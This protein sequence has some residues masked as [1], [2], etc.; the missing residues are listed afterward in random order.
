MENIKA[1]VR[2]RQILC[3]ERKIGDASCVEVLDCDTKLEVKIHPTKTAIYR[4]SKFFPRLT[5]Q[6]I[7]YDQ[8]GVLNLFD[9]AMDGHAVNIFAYG[10]H[11]S[12][13]TYTLFGPP[14]GTCERNLGVVQR[15]LKSIY[16]K[17]DALRVKYNVSLTCVQICEEKFYD[18]FVTQKERNVLSLQRSPTGSISVRDYQRIKCCNYSSAIASLEQV[19][20]ERCSSASPQNSHCVVE[21][22]INLP[23]EDNKSSNLNEIDVNVRSIAL[24]KISFVDLAGSEFITAR[25]AEDGSLI[26]ADHS[27]AVLSKTIDGVEKINN[28]N[29]TVMD[30]A[31][32]ALLCD[33]VGVPGCS[34]LISCIREGF[35]NI[36]ETVKTLQFRYGTYFSPSKYCKIS[37]SIYKLLISYSCVHVPK[38]LKY[39]DAQAKIAYDL[40]AQLHYLNRQNHK[41]RQTI[42][43]APT[44]EL[45]TR[46]HNTPA[47][48]KQER[49]QEKALIAMHNEILKA[50]TTYQFKPRGG[51][52]MYFPSPV[53]GREL[54]L[55]PKKYASDL[56]T[57]R[58]SGLLEGVS[59]LSSVPSKS[60][61]ESW[62]W[63]SS[64]DSRH[65]LR[66]RSSNAP[67]SASRGSSR[68]EAR[69]E[70]SIELKNSNDGDEGVIGNSRNFSSRDDNTSGKVNKKVLALSATALDHI[71]VR[72]H[73]ATGPL[74]FRNKRAVRSPETAHDVPPIEPLKETTRLGFNK[75]GKDWPQEDW[76]KEIRERVASAV[77][78]NERA[79]H[80]VRD[81]KLDATGNFCHRFGRFYRYAR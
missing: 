58:S 18:M 44:W 80:L 67:R 81:P 42:I 17:L 71:L 13:K 32:T 74:V 46:T 60:R 61:S 52:R 24:G 50:N 72:K 29:A 35:L 69:D 9:R 15:S 51:G 70:P 37:E 33:S 68:E 12:G 7:I 16:E 79:K 77:S 8:C 1:V 10:E 47:A 21:V 59:L 48:I 39:F 40:Q 30:S 11:R 6:N 55:K 64:S 76:P 22:H 2:V 27:L 62:G 49:E 14:N 73:G 38:M 3:L 56:S 25:T 41:L 63:A 31:L 78:S 54:P 20:V 34:L 53:A 57:Y 28:D 5:P 65:D 45:H 26:H 75:E 4:C 66:N 43:A 23:V 36:T 19:I